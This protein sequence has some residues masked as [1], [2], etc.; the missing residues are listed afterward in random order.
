MKTALDLIFVILWITAYLTVVYVVAH[1]RR[2]RATVPGLV[3]G[4]AY[5]AEKDAVLW[6]VVFLAGTLLGAIAYFAANALG[7]AI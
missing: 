6:L 2:A 5:R 3:E 4:H 1:Y 7:Q